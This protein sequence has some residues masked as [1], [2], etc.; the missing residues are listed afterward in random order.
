MEKRGQREKEESEEECQGLLMGGRI[1]AE[2][3][4]LVWGAA[5]IEEG[6]WG[7]GSR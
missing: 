5:S 7:Q 3:L 2:R 4:E 1:Q 6:E